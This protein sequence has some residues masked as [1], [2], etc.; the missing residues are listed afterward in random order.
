MSESLLSTLADVLDIR[1][2][3]PRV[4]EI[5]AAVLPHDRMTVGFADGQNEFVAH[6]A[7]N[8]VGPPLQRVKLADAGQFTA[9]GFTLVRDLAHDLAHGVLPVTEPA[10]VWDQWLAA[11]Y[12]SLLAMHI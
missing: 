10:D 2:V 11:G 8:E 5:A 6:A 4:S 1:E 7:S 3:L 12:R 9:A